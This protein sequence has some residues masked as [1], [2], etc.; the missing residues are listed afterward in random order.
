MFP[1]EPQLAAIEF[2]VR[3]REPLE[4]LNI[5]TLKQRGLGDL[6][7]FKPGSFG[8]E[9]APISDRCSLD[10]GTGTARLLIRNTGRGS[11]SELRAEPGDFVITKQGDFVGIVTG[12]ES[13][14]LGRRQEA[15]CFVLPAGFSWD[16]AGTIRLDKADSGFFE[17]FAEGVRNTRT[18]R[19]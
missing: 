16:G 7:L 8:K 11:G 15:K 10:L 13:Y 6:F 14:D 5:D 2:S 1:G 18:P 4:A 9:S 17:S 3:G 19:R 12:I